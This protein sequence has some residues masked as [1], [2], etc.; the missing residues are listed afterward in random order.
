MDLDDILKLALI[1]VG[2]G[3]IPGLKD[4]PQIQDA[5]SKGLS[6]AITMLEGKD[7]GNKSDDKMQR[8]WV[9]MAERLEKE[10]RMPDGTPFT[11]EARLSW[12]KP[13]VRGDLYLRDGKMPDDNTVTTLAEMAISMA[14][15]N[16]L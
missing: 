13:K 9:K 5:V 15:T 1:G 12:L 3:A 16:R 2:S 7:K 10:K 4:K 11:N 8:G 6:T 14:K